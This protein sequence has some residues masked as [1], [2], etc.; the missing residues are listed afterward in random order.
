M[1]KTQG[2]WLMVN[3]QNV[4]EF[5]CQALNRDIWSNSAVKALVKDNFVFW[6]VGK[7]LF[8]LC[9]NKNSKLESI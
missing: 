5:A 1:G 2:R 6:Q 4:Q 7:S 3:I 8:L 9:G